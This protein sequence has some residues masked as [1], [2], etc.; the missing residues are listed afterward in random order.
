MDKREIFAALLAAAAI[1]IVI[2]VIRMVKGTDQEQEPALTEQTQASLVTRVQT[3]TDYWD[4]LQQQQE[5]DVTQDSVTTETGQSLITSYAFTSST[6]AGSTIEGVE[7]IMPATS[8]LAAMTVPTTT[9]T[10]TQITTTTPVV[11]A[12]TFTIVIS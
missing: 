6:V 3:T 8:T 1:C 2:G 5:P 4:Y 11:T 9:T 7:T 12:K 10:T